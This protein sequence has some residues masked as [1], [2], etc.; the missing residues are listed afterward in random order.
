MKALRRA[1]VNKEINVRFGG[2]IR[3][4][5]KSPSSFLQMSEA[6]GDY[7]F[8]LFIGNAS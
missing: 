3:I 8:H 7:V 5:F 4:A 6:L 2:C 1:L